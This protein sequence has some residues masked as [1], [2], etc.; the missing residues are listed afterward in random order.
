MV[1]IVDILIEIED[2]ELGP[3]A[4]APSSMRPGTHQQMIVIS[5]RLLLDGLIGAQRTKHIFRVKPASNHQYGRT[6]VFQ[7]RPDIPGFPVCIIGGMPQVLIPDLSAMVKILAAVRILQRPQ[8]QEEL[9][10]I[11]DRSPENSSRIILY[12]RVPFNIE[13]IIEIEIVQ[14]EKS[15]VMIRV[16]S[17]EFIGDRRLRRDGPDGRVRVGQRGRGIKTRVGDPPE[18][19]AAIVVLN[20]LQQ[21]VDRVPGVRTFICLV[22]RLFAFYARGHLLELAFAHITAPYILVNEYIFLMQQHP[23]GPQGG[24]VDTVPVGPGGVRGALHQERVGMAHILRDINDR[25]QSLA[26]PHGY[27]YFFFKE[28]VFYKN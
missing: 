8:I 4:R 3:A 1:M 13:E 17:D 28:V 21:P 22:F 6:D 9:V 16:I 20:I 19:D 18:P 5:R 7:V 26:I 25:I 12:G 14:Q 27:V 10:S 24:P 15:P 11:G 2:P 23:V